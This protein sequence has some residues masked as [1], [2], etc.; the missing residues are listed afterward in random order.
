MFAIFVSIPLVLTIIP[1]YEMLVESSIFPVGDRPGY[2]TKQSEDMAFTTSTNNAPARDGNIAI[3][4]EFDLAV[5]A[6][7]AEA[8]QLFI[9]R[10]PEHPLAVEAKK[11]LENAI[12]GK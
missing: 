8:L 5:E 7:T 9:Q 4:E 11:V 6:N 1:L 12:E 10:H 3:K 2:E